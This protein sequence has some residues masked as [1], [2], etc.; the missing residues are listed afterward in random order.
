MV[1]VVM[2]TTSNVNVYLVASL[3]AVE[4]SFK[5]EAVERGAISCDWFRFRTRASQMIGS[6]APMELKASP[7]SVFPL[8]I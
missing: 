4:P 7:P 8:V 6:R 5:K 1:D 3:E 2:C